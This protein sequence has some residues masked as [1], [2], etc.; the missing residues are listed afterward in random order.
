M[1]LNLG[2]EV[3]ENQMTLLNGSNL[4]LLWGHPNSVWSQFCS[5]D[6]KFWWIRAVH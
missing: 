3:W 1:V 4:E 5:V 6:A 2:L